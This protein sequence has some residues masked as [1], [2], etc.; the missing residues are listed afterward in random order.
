MPCFD[1]LKMNDADLCMEQILWLG[2]LLHCGVGT[3]VRSHWRLFDGDRGE[4]ADWR[5]V[6]TVTEPA[7]CMKADS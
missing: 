4:G 7:P 3:E 6:F 1:T 5:L 2:T